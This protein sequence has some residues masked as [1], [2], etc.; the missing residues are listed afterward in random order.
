MLKSVLL[1]FSGR[2]VAG[3]TRKQAIQR[4]K[5]LG[6][7]GI[8]AAINFLGEHYKRLSSVEFAEKE[9]LS[10]V[11]DIEKNGLNASVSVKL[12]GLGMGFS[13]RLCRKKLSGIL[14]NAAAKNVFVW[15]DMEQHSFTQKTLE[16]YLHFLPG[17]DNIGITIQSSLKRSAKDVSMLLNL[18]QAKIRLVKGAYNE[19][20]KIAFKSRREI[21]HG[22]SELMGLLFV[23]PN[24]FAIATHDSALIKEAIALSKS[25]PNGKKNFEFQ[26][27]MGLKN[28]LKAKLARQGYAVSEYVPFGSHLLPYVKRRLLERKANIFYALKS[29][30]E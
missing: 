18:R 20:E 23:H 2:W 25:S 4:A 30:F 19:P 11:S 27:L 12:S 10:L 22:F 17:F 16:L 5:K 21:K 9:Y 15:I 24:Y 29:F 14:E 28:R 26:M 8:H 6:R 3:E 13:K 7:Q 1:K